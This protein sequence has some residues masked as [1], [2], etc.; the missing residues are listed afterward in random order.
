MRTALLATVSLM[1]S[2]VA[3]PQ[4]RSWAPPTPQVT[5]F[6]N[7]ITAADPPKSASTRYEFTWAKSGDVALRISTDGE[8]GIRLIPDEARFR[9]VKSQ[10]GKP[11]ELKQSVA[12]GRTYVF[13]VESDLKDLDGDGS[14]DRVGYQLDLSD[15]PSKLKA[16]DA[17]EARI[18]Q[19]E[20]AEKSSRDRTAGHA[21]A[22]ATRDE[23]AARRATFCP[24]NPQGVL[25]EKPGTTFVKASFE[26]CDGTMAIWNIR[27]EWDVRVAFEPKAFQAFMGT[28]VNDLEIA[29]HNDKVLKTAASGRRLAAID[30]EY[31]RKSSMFAKQ[32]AKPREGY[33]AI[34]K[35][36]YASQHNSSEPSAKH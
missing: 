10:Q 19:I 34:A 6:S 26:F 32:H 31:R 1:A 30:T 22:K 36:Y 29:K 25:V 11:A 16:P 9:F 15:E 24:T 5:T 14:P 33:I 23:I 17:P 3:M 28:T 18:A 13:F 12:S 2:C 27:D 8:Q 4:R 20:E 7:V 35:R 21:A